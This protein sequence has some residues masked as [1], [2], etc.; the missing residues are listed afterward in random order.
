MEIIRFFSNDMFAKS[1]PV[2]LMGWNIQKYFE[3]GWDYFARLVCS[4]V[5]YKLETN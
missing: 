3:E 2:E 4:Y 1:I 5:D